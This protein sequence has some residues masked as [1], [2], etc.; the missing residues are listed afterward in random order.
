MNIENRAT[1]IYLK[2]LPPL[3]IKKLVNLYELPTPY[4]EILITIFAENKTGFKILD[5]LEKEHKIYISYFQLLRYTKRALEKFR[6][7]H[8]DFYSQGGDIYEL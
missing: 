2:S 4:K 6:V 7:A 3:T 1:K 5:H 8:K